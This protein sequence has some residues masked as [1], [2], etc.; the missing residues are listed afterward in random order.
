MEAQ[1]ANTCQLFT[2]RIAA[3]PLGAIATENL[4]CKEDKSGLPPKSIKIPA[5]GTFR[6]ED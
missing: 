4:S 5:Q 1:E 2:L 3:K 6:L